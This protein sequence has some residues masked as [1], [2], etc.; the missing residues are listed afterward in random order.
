MGG[1]VALVK[2]FVAPVFVMAG[3]RAGADSA[4]C[5]KRAIPPMPITDRTLE[6]RQG[7]WLVFIASWWVG[8]VGL[9]GVEGWGAA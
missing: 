2:V 6:V 5:K 7:S 4:I 1:P 3:L 9:A 8:R